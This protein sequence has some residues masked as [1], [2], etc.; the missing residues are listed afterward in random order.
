MPTASSAAARDANARPHPQRETP[1]ELRASPG[2]PPGSATT[3]RRAARWPARCS[4]APPSASSSSI[5]SSFMRCDLQQMPPS[6]RRS[7]ARASN[8]RA[9]DVPTGI[10]SVPAISS[11]VYP[12]TSCITNTGRS[13]SDSASMAEWSRALRSAVKPRGS[14]REVAASPR[15]CRCVLEFVSLCAS[16]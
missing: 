12:S 2:A 7:F 3:S 4:R 16:R 6:A 13:F 1:S 10:P 15:C 14:D 5:R 11:C 8:N 9:F